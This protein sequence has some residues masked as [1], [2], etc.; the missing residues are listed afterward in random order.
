MGG[1]LPLQLFS[2]TRPSLSWQPKFT[3]KARQVGGLV[4][5]I[6]A[7]LK[8]K[9]KPWKAKFQNIFMSYYYRDDKFVPFNLLMLIAKFPSQFKKTFWELLTDILESLTCHF[10]NSYFVLCGDF[11]AKIGSGSYNSV[12]S[13]KSVFAE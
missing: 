6:T 12:A 5:F 4:A 3:L 9:Y 11:K 7:D 8:W 2:V 13:T 1:G 10:S